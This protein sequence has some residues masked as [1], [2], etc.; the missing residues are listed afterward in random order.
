MIAPL[1]LLHFAF[2][3]NIVVTMKA[4]HLSLRQIGNSAGIVIPKPVLAQLG[5][6]RETGVQMT[7]EGGAIVLRPSK[8]ARAGWADAAKQIAEAGDDSLVMGEFGNVEDTDLT[9]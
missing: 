8:P 4:M 2:W 1:C 3:N 9:W 5:M 6:S 7:V